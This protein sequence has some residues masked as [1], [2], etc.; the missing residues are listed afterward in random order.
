MS[1]KLV[2]VRSSLEVLFIVDLVGIVPL[3]E[4]IEELVV[5]NRAKKTKTINRLLNSNTQL[6]F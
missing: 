4:L 3:V 2:K 1:N 6:V 5:E